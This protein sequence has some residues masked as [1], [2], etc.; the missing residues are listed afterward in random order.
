MKQWLLLFQ[1][2]W[3]E[4]T[5]NFKV[6]WIPLVF[7]LI[8]MMQP[9]TSY[10]LPQIIEK[11]GNLPEG[12]VFEIP[13][14]SSGVV[15][16]QTLGQYSQVGVLILVLAFMGIVSSE[17]NS[18]VAG[19]ILV[20]PVS[21][22][23]YITAKWLSA[24]LLAFLSFLIGMLSAWYY[25]ELLIGDVVISALIKGILIYGLWLTFLLTLTVLLS[26]LLKSSGVVAFLTLLT[27]ILLSAST[28]LLSKWM[29]WSPA[30]LSTHANA[31][32]IS[33]TPDTNFILSLFV[34]IALIIVFLL[35]SVQ[36]FQRKELG[37]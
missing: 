2:E 7:I 32:F 34:T 27:A 36:M 9:I 37:E 5:R 8:G 26:S 6:V 17:R 31:L 22:T 10:Y 16:A 30:R 21:Y 19:M 14:P 15:L 13:L 33:G 1:K 23:S 29:Q 3:L 18:G 25:T 35:V 24:S 12:A 11:A 4:M 28:S 20:K